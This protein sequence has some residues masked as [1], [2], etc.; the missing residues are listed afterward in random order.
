MNIYQRPLFRQAGGPIAPEMGPMMPPQGMPPAPMAAPQMMPPQGLDPRAAEAVG[1]VEQGA[2]MQAEQYGQNMMAGLD[3]AETPEEV[4]NAMR[5]NQ[6]P[7]EAR[8]G[9]LAELVGQEDAQRTPETVLALLQ[10]VMMMTEQGAMDSGIGELMGQLTGNID[11]MDES[12]A[13][14]EMGQG[15]GSLMMAGVGQQ[16]VANFSQ[17]GAVQRF[18][19]GGEA[20]RL[21]ELYSEMLPVYQ[22][23]M[24]GG[25]DQRDLTK[26]QIFFDI[27][28]RFG[29]FAAGIDPRTGERMQ[30]S[31]AAQFGAA[32]SGLG[33]Q[34]GER[35]GAQDQQERALR[36]A[37]LQGA[38][39]EF[40]AERADERAAARAAA[41]A[42]ANRGIGNA[43]EAVDRE[44]GEVIATEFLA[45]QAQMDAFRA[46]NPGATIRAA[47]PKDSI[48]DS[49]FFTKFGFT[50]EEFYALPI[51]DQN[52]LRGLEAK[53]PS[54]EFIKIR[55]PNGQEVTVRSDSAEA[56]RLTGEGGQRV[57]IT[58][59]KILDPL[60]NVDLL[61]RI[62]FGTATPEEYAIFENAVVNPYVR[63]AEGQMVM[64][65]LAPSILEMQARM[66]IR[67]KPT[68]LPP[69]GAQLAPYVE[70]LKTLMDAQGLRSVDEIGFNLGA[71]PRTFQEIVSPAQLERLAQ[72]ARSAFGPNSALREFANLAVGAIPVVDFD[73]I[74][75]ITQKV[76]A[77]VNSVN[78]AMEMVVRNMSVGKLDAA[79]VERFVATL[80]VPSAF[81]VSPDDAAAKAEATVGFLQNQVN[82]AK[83]GLDTQ[84]GEDR[85]KLETAIF[86]GEQ[87]IKFYMA[88]IE[89][90]KGAPMSAAEIQEAIDA[91]K[92]EELRKML[93]N[94]N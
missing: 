33:G 12:G 94:G 28:D 58:A 11:M 16:P 75:P 73:A 47:V 92:V 19:V 77:D 68:V 80:P 85:Q 3:A 71:P 62:E 9:E 69:N 37:A 76:V 89:G 17:G 14:T 32:A 90:I 4:I 22:G 44:T 79:G 67:G 34:I 55:M 15:V 31:A 72:D 86:Q 13:P 91:A 52:R 70:R 82:A 18:Q 7:L 63:N 38:A 2:A 51:D 56:D 5:G 41:A 23:V 49:D 84:T 93:P 61:N 1:Q 81:T 50:K 27:A 25:E 35:L 88:L 10:P 20:S 74:A 78:L 45:T 57:S 83:A 66:A 21:Q 36:V 53:T 8:Y 40:S 29:A 65:Q 42:A 30:G 24:G 6:R 64:G 39:G 46:A 43:Y 26:A 60:L 48:T 87:A 54:G 59:A